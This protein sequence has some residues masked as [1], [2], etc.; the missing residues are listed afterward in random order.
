MAK[1]FEENTKDFYKELNGECD[2]EKLLDIAKQGIFLEKPLLN[3]DSIKDH[4][5]VVD[6]SIISGQLYMINNKK[7]YKR[8]KFWHKKVGQSEIINYL[9]NISKFDIYDL[10]IVNKY[11]I[12]ELLKE[13]DDDFLIC[14]IVNKCY[15]NFFLLYLYNYSYI[16]TKVFV[17]FFSDPLEFSALANIS[18]EIFKYFYSNVHKHLLDN[19]IEMNINS[20]ITIRN[21][22]DYMIMD[23]GRDIT[24]LNYCSDV[25]KKYNIIIRRY[26]SYVKLPFI[27]SINSLKYFSSKIYKKNSLY[28]KCD[29]NY[30]SEFVNSVF[31][32]EGLISLEDVKLSENNDLIMKYGINLNKILYYEII[33]D[34]SIDDTEDDIVEGGMNCIYNTNEQLIKIID[35]QYSGKKNYYFSDADL[36]KNINIK[37]LR[38]IKNFLTNYKKVDRILKDPNYILNLDIEINSYYELFVIKMCYIVSLIYNNSSR[39]IIHVLMYYENKVFGNE[40]RNNKIVLNDSYSNSKYICKIYKLLVNTPHELFNS[41][42]IY[43]N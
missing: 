24:I 13:K 12:D 26:S 22:I 8:L 11:L 10:I 20:R 34:K 43:K 9:F 25:I 35:P 39:F 6:I 16:Y 38:S 1:T 32:N 23:Y 5:Y 37:S 3:Y 14:L 15:V 19:Y 4:E 7:Q 36:Y 30:V 27:Y 31:T 17:L 40:L 18:F 28:F 41:Y 33:G 21:I 2:P 29:N 42:F